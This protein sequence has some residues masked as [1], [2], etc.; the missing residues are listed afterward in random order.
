MSLF[1]RTTNTERCPH[2]GDKKGLPF[3]DCPM[4]HPSALATSTDPKQVHGDKKIPL[5]LIP[6]AGNEEC[7]KALAFGAAKYGV[8]NWL[9]HPVAIMTYLH[10]LKRHIDCVLDGEDIDPESNAHHLGHVMA[11]CAIILDAA[12]HGTLKDNRVLPASKPA[13]SHAVA[14]SVGSLLSTTN[15]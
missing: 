10:A 11:G 3:C 12:K 2:C 13:G 1:R 4:S 15:L 7:A 8:R 6:P 9:D 14:G 5:A